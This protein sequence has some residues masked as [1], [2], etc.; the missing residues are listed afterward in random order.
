M[1]HVL[2]GRKSRDN[3]ERIFALIDEFYTMNSK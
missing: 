2:F 1:F 3:R